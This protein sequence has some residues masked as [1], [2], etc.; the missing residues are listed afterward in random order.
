MRMSVECARE[1]RTLLGI[2]GNQKFRCNLT[3]GFTSRV[4]DPAVAPASVVM[5]VKLDATQRERRAKS[6]SL[7]IVIQAAYPSS[8]ITTPVAIELL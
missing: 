7:P 5:I 3:H 4:A 2:D 8:T 6:S 1:S